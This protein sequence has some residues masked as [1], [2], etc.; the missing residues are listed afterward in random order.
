MSLGLRREWSES[1]RGAAWRGAPSAP[2]T[3]REPACCVLLGVGTVGTAVLQR[4]DR[5]RSQPGFVGLRL[6]GGGGL[7][8]QR[9]R[10]RWISGG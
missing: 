1:D 9:P 4:W 7:A 3:E 8:S 2:W 5:L 6:V 10:R